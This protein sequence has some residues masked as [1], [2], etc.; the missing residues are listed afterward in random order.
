MIAF[1]TAGA[2]L[3]TG[4]EHPDDMLTDGSLPNTKHA[5]YR[6]SSLEEPMPP[7]RPALHMLCG[8]ICA[9][10]SALAARLVAE[11]GAVALSED[12]WLAGLY[13]EEMASIADFLRYS[14]R[15]RAVVAP[16]VAALLKAGLSVV[17]D[18]QA[19]TV[20]ARAW[21]KE[22]LAGVDA[23]HRLHWLDVPD[24][25]CLARLEARN[26]SGAHPFSVTEAQFHR[27]SAHF[28]APT[29]EEGLVIQ[30]HAIEGP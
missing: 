26:R 10:K 21:I 11:H 14:A 23:D 3:T 20:E 29:A 12:A 25:V 6:T 28:V 16:H 13:G 4:R 30:R 17:L 15:L 27:V 5:T 1:P 7:R 19:N 22:I 9:G 8:K 24:A 2:G 18:Y